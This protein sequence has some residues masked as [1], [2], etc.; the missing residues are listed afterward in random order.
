MLV[1]STPASMV[2]IPTCVLCDCQH[3]LVAV[4]ICPRPSPFA[5]VFPKFLFAVRFVIIYFVVILK[6]NVISHDSQD[7]LHDGALQLEQSPHSRLYDCKYTSHSS[8]SNK[9]CL[10]LCI[11]APHLNLHS[12]TTNRNICLAKRALEHTSLILSATNN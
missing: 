4:R 1:S 2:I 12:A 9:H 6:A 8:A 5:S 7:C 10:T 3:C 11:L